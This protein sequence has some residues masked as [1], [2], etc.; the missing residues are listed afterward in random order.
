MKALLLR[1]P[2]QFAMIET[3]K[4]VPQ[5]DEALVRVLSAAI[6]GSEIHGYHGKH[7]GRKAPA[8]MG[9]KV[10]GV[11]DALGERAKSI[12]KVKML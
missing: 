8:I 6:C 7:F 5:K 1:N 11:V 3:P 10:C 2:H 9:Y 4:P 12:F